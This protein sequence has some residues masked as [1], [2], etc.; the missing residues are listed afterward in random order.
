MDKK[1]FLE[2]IT[3]IGTLEDMTDVREHLTEL[4]TEVSEVFDNNETLTASNRQFEEDNEKLRKANMSLFLKVGEQKSP[5]QIQKDKTG[6]EPKPDKEKKS[7][8]DLLKQF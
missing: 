8:D 4:S 6:I 5:E 7:F 2:R 1:S 3:E